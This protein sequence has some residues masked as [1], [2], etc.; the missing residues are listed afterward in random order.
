MW[1]RAV[2][3]AFQ[4]QGRSLNLRPLKFALAIIYSN[5][6]ASQQRCFDLLKE[7]FRSISSPKPNNCAVELDPQLLSTNVGLRGLFSEVYHIFGYAVAFL[8]SS[9]KGKSVEGRQN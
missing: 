3:D 1:S 2:V 8:K 5:D 7:N 9:G 4:C 6:I